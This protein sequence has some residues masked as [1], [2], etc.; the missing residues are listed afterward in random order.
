M[1]VTMTA[2]VASADRYRALARAEGVAA[3]L[4]ALCHDCCADALP[5]GPAG[6]VVV[7]ADLHADAGFRWRPAGPVARDRVTERVLCTVPVAGDEL[8]ALHCGQPEPVPPPGFLLG[9]GYLRLGLSEA[10]LD[11]AVSYLS[12]RQAGD[13]ALLLQQMVKGALADAVTEQL[14]TR[15]LADELADAGTDA[16]DARAG[17]EPDPARLAYLHRQVSDADRII[18]RLLGAYGFTSASP[19]QWGYASEL[20]A[21]AWIGSVPDVPDGVAGEEN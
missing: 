9:L 10:L 7:P 21:S 14:E 8:V 19:G 11:A 16:D 4:R 12:G 3:A 2:P 5:V 18:L 20:L 13:T 15:L 1:T 17:A 6:H